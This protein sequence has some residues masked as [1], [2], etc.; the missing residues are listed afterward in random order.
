MPSLPRR[1]HTLFSALFA[2]TLLLGCATDVQRK[3]GDS[4]PSIAVQNKLL[5]PSNGGRI[6]TGE[7]LQPGDII[8]TADNG[9]QSASIRLITLSPVSHAAVYVG[10]Q[11]VIEAVGSGIR[12]RSVAQLIAEEATVVAFRHPTIN[13]QQTAALNAFLAQHV[14][15]KYNYVG[16]MLQSPFVIE[17]R[18]CELPFVPSLVRDFCVRGVAAIQLGLGRSDQFFCSQLVLEGYRRAGVP[19][20]HADPRLITPGDL[21][22]MREGDVPSVRTLQSLQYVGHLKAPPPTTLASS[23]P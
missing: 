14:G 21:L 2:S 23:T 8:L 15:Q 12:Q 5:N 10:E 18:V 16:I 6:I 22:H 4:L 20:T 17:R 3:Q 13:A 9:L 11:Q 19:L 7:G 1:T